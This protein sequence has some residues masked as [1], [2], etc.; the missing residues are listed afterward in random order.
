MGSGG[1]KP[2]NQLIRELKEAR[3]SLSSDTSWEKIKK[4]LE[5]IADCLDAWGRAIGNGM[6]S[7]DIKI[8]EDAL[9]AFNIANDNSMPIALEKLN[10]QIS[11]CA[12]TKTTQTNWNTLQRVTEEI[13]NSKYTRTFRESFKTYYQAYKDAKLDELKLPKRLREERFSVSDNIRA[14]AKDLHDAVLAAEADK[15]QAT[16]TDKS[17]PAESP[18]P[19]GKPEQP[20]R[21]DQ[22]AA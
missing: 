17:T 19:A 8:L 14:F 7:P 20:H 10:A 15:N 16:E 2:Y 13:I 9:G 21:K 18:R 12:L 1:A 11:K 6:A 4:L 3:E 5:D 22:S